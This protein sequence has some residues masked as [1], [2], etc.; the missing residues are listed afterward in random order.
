MPG[1][2]LANWIINNYGRDRICLVQLSPPWNTTG[3]GVLLNK[4]SLIIIIN[5]YRLRFGCPQP[6]KTFLRLPKTPNRL[7]SLIYSLMTF[8]LL[9]LLRQPVLSHLLE[10][11]ALQ[12]LNVLQILTRVLNSSQRK[13]LWLHRSGR[14]TLVQ[15]SLSLMHNAWRT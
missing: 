6:A 5:V 7:S 8:F 14:C 2:G 12:T 3:T 15:R 10:Y 9:I 4:T 1:N 13:I 11:L